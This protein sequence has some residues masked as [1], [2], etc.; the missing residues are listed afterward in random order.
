M[1][2]D[3]VL[4]ALELAIEQAVCEYFK[5]QECLVDI[6]DR[7]VNPIF[8]SSSGSKTDKTDKTGVHWVGG[9]LN[10]PEISFG[11]LSKNIIK[12]CRKLFI[13]NLILM[14]TVYLYEK[15][16]PRAHQ[17]VEGNIIDVNSRRLMVHLGDNVQGIMLRCEWVPK[18]IPLYRPGSV[19]RFFV[20]KIL[21]TPS[22]VTVYLSRGSKRLPAVLLKEKMPW[23]GIHVLKR[24][25]GEKTWVQ[26]RD[27]IT[28][29]V[30]EE[31]RRELNGEIIEILN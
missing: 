10:G 30:I 19:F 26:T 31:V 24:I 6:E 16:K 7:I 11:M 15:W 28:Q 13:R 25:R 20:T 22:G 5:T 27:R 2:R 29:N 1:P 14:E 17:A 12:R 18:E 3:R 23:A 4:Y 8:Y 9:G 21:Y